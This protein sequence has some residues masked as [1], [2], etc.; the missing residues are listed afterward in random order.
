MNNESECSE[1]VGSDGQM[2]QYD[3]IALNRRDR[4]LYKVGAY[5]E[6]VFVRQEL[7]QPV[8]TTTGGIYDTHSR[9][10]IEC[11]SRRE[12]ESP[13]SSKINAALGS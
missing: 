10:L 11:A 9:C 3:G 5:V 12:P 6:L 1:I 2:F 4:K 7:K 13:P 8:L